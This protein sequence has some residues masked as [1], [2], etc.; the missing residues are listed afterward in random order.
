MLICQYCLKS[1]SCP[2]EYIEHLRKDHEKVHFDK[3]EC[4]NDN[5]R[6]EF[7]KRNRFTKHL[8]ICSKRIKY[9]RTNIDSTVNFNNLSSVD[10]VHSNPTNISNSPTLNNSHVVEEQ[11]QL[12]QSDTPTNFINNSSEIVD[13]TYSNEEQIHLEQDNLKECDKIIENAVFQII[14]KLHSKPNFTRADVYLIQKLIVSCLLTSLLNILDN[15]C[16]CECQIKLDFKRILNTFIKTFESLEN[17]HGLIKQLTKKNLIVNIDEKGYEFTITKEVGVV[18]KKGCQ[19]FGNIISTGMLLPIHFQI[20]EFLQRKNRL[21][22]ML[23]YIEYF[24]KPSDTISHFLQ[25]TTWK[26]IKSHFV[27][28]E[29]LIPIGIYTDGMQF[30]SDHGPHN[31]SSDMIY[32]YYPGLVDPLHRNNIHVASI[33]GSKN[34]KYYGS[35][36]CLA[37]LVR[38]LFKLFYD[39]INLEIDGKITNVKVVLCQIIGDNL[40]LNAILEYIINF[41]K[42]NF[43]CRICKLP[44]ADAEK[45]CEEVIELLRNPENYKIDLNTNSSS[46][47]GIVEDCVFNSLTYFHCTLNLSLDL[48]HDFFEGIFKY[49]ICQIIL[50]FIN[51][52]IFNLEE[53][54]NRINHFKYGEQEVRYIPNIIDKK[55]LEANNLNMTSKEA[56]QFLYLLPLLIGDL[57]DPND[58]VWD[59]LKTLLKLIELCL[60]SSFDETSLLYLTSLVK[61]HNTLYIKHFGPLKPKMH[62]ITHLSSSIRAMGPP[63][64]YMSFRMEMKH[65][66]FKIYAHCTPNRRNIAKT[67]AKKYALHFANLLFENDDYLEI[68]TG[69]QVTTKFPNKINDHKCYHKLNFRGTDFNRGMFIPLLELGTYNLYEI[70]EIAVN[71]EGIS[72]IC[73]NVGSLNYSP[74]FESYSLNRQNSSEDVKIFPLEA[75]KSIPLYI[76][77]SKTKEEFIRPKIFFDK[78]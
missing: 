3:Y 10:N 71:I 5:C 31:D 46:Q 58:E 26:A 50:N 70:L 17:D 66:F 64:H 14:L 27:S 6:I 29:I 60:S 9:D 25:G 41:S 37:P 65:R 34:I 21:A 36:R 43:Y 73:K 77:I 19:Y 74:H 22:T 69:R 38:E 78:I 35:G 67:F 18:F 68:Q 7:H 28:S 1:L 24:S 57:I 12:F 30:N 33:I 13:N 23:K 39:G 51:R 55:K 75:F 53:L 48:M 44:R 42:A 32:Y 2:K 47:T 61:K 76:Y 59:L 45:Y 20:Q 54:N 62:L 72:I 40:A 15:V 52:K 49:D 11:N 56:W 4:P 63:R 8:N 16:N